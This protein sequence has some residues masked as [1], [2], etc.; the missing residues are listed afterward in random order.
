MVTYLLDRIIFTIN[1]PRVRLVPFPSPVATTFLLFI[2]KINSN[3]K[4][5]EK[6]QSSQEGRHLQISPSACF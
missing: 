6:N 5:K 3:T 1:M 2:L 4:K